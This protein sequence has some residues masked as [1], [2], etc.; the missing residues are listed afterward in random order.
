MVLSENPF[1]MIV[2]GTL[3]LLVSAYGVV[4][5]F[6]TDPADDGTAMTPLRGRSMQR[7]EPAP[8]RRLNP[9]V[10]VYGAPIGMGLLAFGLWQA[11]QQDKLLHEGVAVVGYLADVAPGEN[12]PGLVYRFED[13]EGVVHDGSYQPGILRYVTDFQVG[14]E[15]TIVYDPKD[16]RRHLLDVGD[17][18]RA[19]ARGRRLADGW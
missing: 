4:Q 6:E 3:V 18:R 7:P 5:L 1:R 8:R 14:Q 12:K 11:R 15:V 19:D 9:L 16:P 2:M 13:D 10:L 17:V